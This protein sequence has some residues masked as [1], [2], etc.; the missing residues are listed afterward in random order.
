[1]PGPIVLKGIDGVQVSGGRLGF[2]GVLWL[3]R[4]QLGMFPLLLTLLNRDYPP[5]NW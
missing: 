2:R 5:K 3:Q 4:A 1:M